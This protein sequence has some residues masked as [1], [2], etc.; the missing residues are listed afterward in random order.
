MFLTW[1]FEFKQIKYVLLYNII[2][3][4]VYW[5]NSLDKI[6]KKNNIVH[7]S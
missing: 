3:I 7:K 4:F 6:R 2:I 5:K 1:S